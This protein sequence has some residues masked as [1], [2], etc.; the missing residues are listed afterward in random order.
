MAADANDNF[1]TNFNSALRDDK[2]V[3]FRSVLKKKKEDF[4]EWELFKPIKDVFL[5]FRNVLGSV[6]VN[7]ILEERDGQTVTSKSFNIVSQTGKSG[8]GMD[9]WGL[10]QWGL[11][12]ADAEASSEDLLRRTYLAKTARTY[13]VEV[14]T[15]GR[16]DSYELLGIKTLVQ[17]QGIGT[18]PHEWNIS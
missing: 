16:Q 13:Q 1:V 14:I 3:A 2:G 18:T 9:Q 6:D 7:I 11:T 17:P 8:W 5:N 12:N 10:V 15:S 4:D